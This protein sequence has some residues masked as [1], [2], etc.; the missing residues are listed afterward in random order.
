MMIT[1]YDQLVVFKTFP[2]NLNSEHLQ[3]QGFATREQNQLLFAKTY[4]NAPPP[5]KKV[6]ETEKHANPNTATT[7]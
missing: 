1:N 4:P 7:S 5:P 2:T 6:S 3:T